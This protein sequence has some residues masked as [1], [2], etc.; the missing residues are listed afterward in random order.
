[1]SCSSARCSGDSERISDCIAAIRSASCSID[2]VERLGA[3]EEPAVPRQEPVDV[4]LRRLLARDPLL[5]QVVEVAHH[6]ALGSQV[7]GRHALDGVGQAPRE[8]VQHRRPQPVDQRV[9]PLPRLGIEEV[10][11][12][13]RPH[14]RP[15]VR[16]QRVEPVEPLRGDAPEHP[17]ELRVGRAVG[18]ALAGLRLVEPPLH[19][20]PLLGHDLVQLLADLGQRVGQPA[21]LQHLAPALAQPVHE[22]A[23]PAQVA[24]ARARRSGARAGAAA[25]APP[26]RRL[27]R[28]GRR[29]ARRPARPR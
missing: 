17:L 9:E 3:R 14:P 23:Q 15:D 20:G 1:M 8:P 6:L 21:L 5:E 22:V 10:V 2:V 24:P 12:L 16:R 18:A 26:P 13:E 27:A 11:V 28:A 25:A 29:T 7:L 4:L 19:A